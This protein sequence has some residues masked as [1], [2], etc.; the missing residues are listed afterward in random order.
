MAT[1]ASAGRGVQ[2]EDDDMPSSGR[3]VSVT[4]ATVIEY[5]P[6]IRV[7]NTQDGQFLVCRHPGE[8][9]THASMRCEIAG[10]KDVQA[11]WEPLSR[12][13]RAGYVLRSLQVNETRYGPS[14]VL[15]WELQ[16]VKPRK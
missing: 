10:G 11:G 12:L 2:Q 14:L 8:T 6:S 4:N 3:A 9:Y 15:F 16:P 7:W 5:L 1:T 13:T